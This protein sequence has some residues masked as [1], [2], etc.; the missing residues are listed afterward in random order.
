MP[1]YRLSILNQAGDCK[2]SAGDKL[3]KRIMPRVSRTLIS[4]ASYHPPPLSLLKERD[5]MNQAIRH[6]LT[7]EGRDAF[8]PAQEGHLRF[9]H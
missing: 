8:M 1:F 5:E 7:M 6:P 9:F 2:G 3:V 4:F